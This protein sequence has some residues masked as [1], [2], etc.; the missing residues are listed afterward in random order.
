M[1]GFVEAVDSILETEK[2]N[3]HEAESRVQQGIFLGY[4]RRTTEYIVGTGDTIYKCLSHHDYVTKGA[5][6]APAVSFPTGGSPQEMEKIQVRGREFA[7]R[8]VYS[9]QEEH[10]YKD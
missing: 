7:P 9:G 5:K 1:I 10:R 3:R 6:T 2:G 8:K 4:I